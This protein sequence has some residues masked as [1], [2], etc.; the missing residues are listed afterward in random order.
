MAAS[1]KMSQETWKFSSWWCIK[2]PI[3]RCIKY[4][5]FFFSWW[6]PRVITGIALTVMES[7]SVIVNLLVFAH[8][9]R[10]HRH[11]NKFCVILWNT[12]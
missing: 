9:R 10:G 1:Y 2:Y 5:L 11:T 6:N 12:K 8:V 3:P 4:A 7:F